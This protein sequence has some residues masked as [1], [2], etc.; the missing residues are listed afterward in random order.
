VVGQ[1]DPYPEVSGR[2]LKMLQEAG[3]EVVCG[4]LEEECKSLN[5]RF[6]TYILKQRPY[7]ILKWAQSADGF[8]DRIRAEND[9]QT[10]VRFS[11]SFTQMLVHKLRAE[12]AA[13]MVGK[14]T[15]LLDKPSL[16]VRF[17]KGN[18]P[19][20]IIAES[21]IPLQ[22]QLRRLHDEKIQSLI[23]EGGARLL[24]AFLDEN[25][26]DEIRIEISPLELKNGVPAPTP[27][28]RLKNVQKCENSLIFHYYSAC[29]P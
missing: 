23:V 24:N 1:V 2:G 18:N 7:L 11:N 17:W 5:V 29:N 8:I 16:D 26:W 10:P 12:E 3:V 28:G 9:G 20:K 4:V 6:M 21:G 14:K 13:I 25:L 19:V 15:F 27:K 22:Q